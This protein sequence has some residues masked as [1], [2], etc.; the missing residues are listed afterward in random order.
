[1]IPRR[2]KQDPQPHPLGGT[3]FALPLG[4]E[5]PTPTMPTAPPPTLVWFKRDL[6]VDDHAPL[7]Q[8]AAR[9]A[10]IPLFIYEPEGLHSAEFDGT[11]LQFLNES[12]A[13][14]DAAL[15]GVGGRLIT[16]HG[17]AA[18]VLEDL[19]AATG[20]MR[21]VSHEETGNAI[22]YARDRR[23]KRWS[24]AQ[25]IEWI[26][27]PQTGVVRALKNR[28]GWSRTWAVRMEAP[29]AATP[30]RVIVPDAI[31][32]CGI[33]SH[34]QLGVA[35]VANVELQRGG[36]VAANTTLASF[37]DE[38]GAPYSRAMSSPLTGE[39]HCSRLSTHLAFGTLSM[40]QVWQATNARRR[41]L[42][43]GDP[44]LRKGWGAA[45]RAFEARL[46]WH[47]HFMQKLEDEPRL[48]FENLHRACDGLRENDFSRERFEAW[49]AGRTGYPMVDACMRF[50]RARRWLNFRMR[51]MVVSFAA[52]D[53]WLHWREPAVW[54][55]RHFL[56]FEPGIHFSQ[57]QMQSGT[58]GINTLRMYNP[59]KQALDHDPEGVFI[60]RWVPELAAVP[61]PFL[62][63]PWLLTTGDQS[64]YGVHLGVDYPMPIVDHKAAVAAARAKIAAVRRS[65]EG[66]E[67]AREVVKKHGSRKRPSQPS[68]RGKRA[69]TNDDA[70]QLGL[71][72]GE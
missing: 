23:V 9:G 64:R 31:S 2:K 19:R 46:H 50:V 52:Y 67:Q 47:C 12:L 48:E 45:L 5:L 54:M 38:R 69:A 7:A 63:E 70:L 17:E 72:D 14:L 25:G 13:D 40:R 42:A 32:S 8:A 44:G 55:G 6:R 33:L 21:L 43:D 59:T 49:C 27:V 36:T 57:F 11:H 24:R 65:A 61:V 58:T 68:T 26:E 30:M 53:L 35:R 60:R 3:S 16:R 18:A 4:R 41:A 71:F 20:A 56:D 51:A 1:M 28:D 62:F 37:L 34:E 66:R 22:T 39:D 29:I 10:V 15:R